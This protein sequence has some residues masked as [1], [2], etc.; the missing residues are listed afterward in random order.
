LNE[1]KKEGLISILVYAGDRAV[2]NEGCAS[3]SDAKIW[4]I[5]NNSFLRDSM[6]NR[7]HCTF[8]K[9]T[10]FSSRSYIIFHDKINYESD[11][12]TVYASLGSGVDLEKAFDSNKAS[13]EKNK[14]TKF[15]KL[16]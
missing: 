15:A 1:C 11:D 6:F 5:D 8:V 10:M 14:I 12:L 7:K 13:W 4:C 9:K 2:C 3:L 16:R